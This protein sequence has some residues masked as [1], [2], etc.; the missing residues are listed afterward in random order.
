ADLL[1]AA[2]A[3]DEDTVRVA[4]LARSGVPL[5]QPA[6]GGADPDRALGRR[7]PVALGA[8]ARREDHRRRAVLRLLPARARAA[9]ALTDG[10]RA[11]RRLA[12]YLV[13]RARREPRRARGVRARVRDRAGRARRRLESSRPGGV[14]VLR[15]RARGDCARVHP[16]HA[17][18]TSARPHE[19]ARGVLV[20]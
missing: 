5:Q 2:A 18:A 13:T 8:R 14:L 17:G 15:V 1:A 16:R 11:A 19:L 10:D 12:A 20:A 4:G 3:A 7:L 6:V 9:V